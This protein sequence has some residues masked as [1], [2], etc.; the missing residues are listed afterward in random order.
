M[1]ATEWKKYN[2]KI[3]YAENTDISYYYW[4]R[5]VNGTV[6][7]GD[8]APVMVVNNGGVTAFGKVRN[9]YGV[10]PVF[11]LDKSFFSEVKT[12]VS[13]LGDNVKKMLRDNYSADELKKIYDS[14]EITAIY[15]KL[16]PRAQTVSISGM[17]GTGNVLEGAY[18]FVSLENEEEFNSEYRWLRSKNKNGPFSVIK[19]ANS[20]EFRI[21]DIDEGYYF[22]FEVVPK[23]KNSIGV[24]ARSSSTGYSAEKDEKCY[25]ENVYVD[26]NAETN[27]RLIARYNYKDKNMDV[28]DGTV[29]KWQTSENGIDFEDISGAIG[30]NY[31]IPD[32]MNGKYIRFRIN[33]K[34]AGT[35]YYGD[36]VYSDIIGPVK[37]AAKK[38]VSAII[39]ERTAKISS[40]IDTD[41]D[42]PFWI[43]EFAGEKPTVK[44]LGEREYQL[45]GE[46]TTVK[47]G[48]CILNCNKTDFVYSEPLPLSVNNND[49]KSKEIMLNGG[50]KHIR[51]KCVGGEYAHSMQIYFSCQ[52]TKIE[53]AAAEQFK[54]SI[55]ENGDT[56]I[57]TGI[58]AER[59]LLP[60]EIADIEV[61]GNGKISIGY[62]EGTY[63]IN[64]DI[65]KTTPDVYFMEEGEMDI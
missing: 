20:K 36:T 10:R 53:S 47:A 30:L 61:S 22:V 38:S 34:S 31:I 14:D 23:T 25:A 26:G 35:D 48:I 42:I 17:T 16:P 52:G 45:T 62:A 29:I 39:N 46:E 4:L 19:G 27:E 6:P 40:D 56:I 24:A 11:Y 8:N 43:V 9:G 21:R 13:R 59:L 64:G 49:D 60:N 1:S 12:D 28:E 63:E 37:D 50:K 18:R 44:N 2:D 51:L 58:S 57:L 33:V 65:V 5:S 55:S 3:G 41:R 54:V 15:K 32:D 7:P